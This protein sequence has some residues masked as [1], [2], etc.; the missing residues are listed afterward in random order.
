[1]MVLTIMASKMQEVM[2]SSTVQALDQEVDHL[3]QICKLMVP[4]QLK[5]KCPKTLGSQWSYLV[6][7]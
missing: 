2:A 1:M 4:G 6:G 5:I 7:L 3:L